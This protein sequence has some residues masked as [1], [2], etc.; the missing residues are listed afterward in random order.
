MRQVTCINNEYYEHIENLKVGE[1]YYLDTETLYI[2][3]TGEASAI[4]YTLNHTK[5]GMLPLKI[6][7][8]IY[9]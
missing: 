9:D 7:T 3:A 5:L 8:T 6:F 2:G 1:K 4:F